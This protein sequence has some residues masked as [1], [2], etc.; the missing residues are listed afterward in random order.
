MKIAYDFKY[1]EKTNDES[2]V[3]K[4]IMSLS[5]AKNTHRSMTT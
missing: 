5:S 4:S 3:I 1:L 2:Q